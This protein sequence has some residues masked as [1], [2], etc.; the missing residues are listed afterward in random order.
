MT[1]APEPLRLFD[2][3]RGEVDRKSHVETGCPRRSDDALRAVARDAKL[4]TEAQRR[5]DCAVE[6]ARADGCSWRR[7][8]TASGVRFQTFH[9]AHTSRRAL[10]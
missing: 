8:G 1:A 5:L 7:I 10:N 9:R 3:D 2:D 6:A 4:L